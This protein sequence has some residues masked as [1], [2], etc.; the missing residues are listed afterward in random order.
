M[1]WTQEAFSRLAALLTRGKASRSEGP[2]LWA[3][4]GLSVPAGYPTWG[5]LSEQL[6][7]LSVSS[8]DPGLEGTSLINAFAAANGEGELT[9]ALARLFPSRKHLPVHGNLVAL[10]WDSIVTTNY[11]DLL[12][13]ACRDRKIDFLVITLEQNLDI[14]NARRFPIIKAHGSITDYRNVILDT[15]SYQDYAHTYPRALADLESRLRKHSMVFFGC[16]MTDPRLLEWLRR[17]GPGGRSNLKASTAVLTEADWG[18][19]PTDTQELLREAHIEK[20]LIQNHSDIP[21]LAE[22]L[23][24]ELGVEEGNAGGHGGSAAGGINVSFLAKFLDRKPHV[25]CVVGALPGRRRGFRSAH[26]F[27]LCGHHKHSP[28]SLIERL[29]K[30]DIRQLASKSSDISYF[31]EPIAVRWP[32]LEDTARSL[33]A[34]LEALFVAM[35]RQ[36]GDWSDIP[37]AAKYLHE[38][39]KGM[40]HKVWCVHHTIET[41]YWTRSTPDLVS[42]YLTFWEEVARLDPEMCFIVFLKLVY[43]NWS[44]SASFTKKRFELRRR[45]RRSEVFRDTLPRL[46]SVGP[47]DV[48]A[49]LREHHIV[50]PEPPGDLI[51]LWFHR[52]P[53]GLPM[54]TME[55]RI[56]KTLGNWRAAG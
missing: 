39:C 49:W 18:K 30:E 42:S 32:Y 2:V 51:R 10:P 17:L 33:D 48:Y 29:S 24:R 14:L 9:D 47:S 27:L 53:L 55:Y 26:V 13:D 40:P 37:S 36:G 46:T 6:R 21:V 28:D 52:R 44:G 54:E 12:E 41:S 38:S 35:Q 34:L 20:F 3:G 50:P 23:C 19:L 4:A 56:T 22:A 5:K 15:R 16:S 31:S 1:G 43:G 45:C 7:E 11:D 25:S 8:L